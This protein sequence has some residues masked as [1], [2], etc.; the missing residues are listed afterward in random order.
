MRVTFPLALLLA[1]AC[2]DHTVPEPRGPVVQTA[3]LTGLYEGQG[4][5]DEKSRLCM[6]AQPAGGIS[7]GIVTWGPGGGVCSG[8]GEAIREGDSVELTMGGDE[9]CAIPARLEGVRLT[10]SE[11]VPGGCAY[12]CSRSASFAGGT[13]EKTGGT[14]QDAMRAADLAGDPLCY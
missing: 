14:A 2:G 11:N 5:G 9:Q 13:F 8:S 4:A 10:L 1:A 7:F 12:Y 3:D 6:I